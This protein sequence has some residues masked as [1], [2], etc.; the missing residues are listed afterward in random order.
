MRLSRFRPRFRS[1]FRLFAAVA[2][3]LTVV[4]GVGLVSTAAHAAVACRVTYSVG[5]QWPGG[6]TG[7][8]TL[9]NLGDP[10]NGWTLTWSFGA[11]QQVTQAWNATV[12]QSGAQVTAR[13]AGYN[14]AIATGASVSFGFNGS[15]TGGNPAP[16]SFALNGVACTGGPT[17]P[18]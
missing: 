1:R 6:F 10:L 13:N 7:N 18:P 16:A 8:V 5:S 12:T 14:G 11:G 2:V 15:W 3:P 4:A 17:T 9:N